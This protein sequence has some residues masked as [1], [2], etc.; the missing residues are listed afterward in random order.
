MSSANFTA[1]AYHGEGIVGPAESA[2]FRQ[3]VGYEPPTLDI[4]PTVR[5]TKE[6][7]E[8][9]LVDFGAT[10]V[11][12]QFSG[13]ASTPDTLEAVKFASGPSAPSGIAESNVSTYRFD[14]EGQ[15]TLSFGEDT[16]I[17]WDLSTLPGITDAETVTVYK[18]DTPG[19][20]DFVPLNTS[21][22]GGDLVVSTGSFSEFVFAS[23]SNPLPVEMAGFEGTTTE[24]GVRLTWQ[25]ASETGNAGFRV[26]RRAS[27]GEWEQVGRVDGSGS[28]TTAQSYRFVDG[29]LPYA[30]DALTYRLKQV[31][32]DGTTALSEPITVE[33]GTV[34]KVQLLDTFP[35][36]A[37]TRATVRYAIPEGIAATDVTMRLYDVLGRQVRSLSLDAQAGR[38]QRRMNVGNL[39]SGVYVLRLSTDDAVKTQRLTVVR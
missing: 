39:P 37:R 21:V 20:G 38:H 22:D 33:R 35:N 1:T 19:E 24:E 9:G 12:I 26:Q 23:D 36:P 6:V 3:R 29:D 11:S 14:I 18:R 31:D 25:T 7:S 32:T 5:V 4:F 34:T 27:Q 16:L 10:G 8:D 2:S 28:T 13:V 30:A 15:G 17:R